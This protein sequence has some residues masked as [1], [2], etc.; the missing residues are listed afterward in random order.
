MSKRRKRE[1]ELDAA[2][3][4]DPDYQE[5]GR[6][7]DEQTARQKERL[8][9]DI[10]RQEA[11]RTMTTREQVQEELTKRQEEYK[12]LKTQ[13]T[14]R[15][16]L[17][18][19]KDDPEAIADALNEAEILTDRGAKWTKVRVQ[20]RIAPL[21]AAMS[22][23]AETATRNLDHLAKIIGNLSSVLAVGNSAYQRTRIYLNSEVSAPQDTKQ[24][25]PDAPR[26]PCAP[27]EDEIPAAWMRTLRRMIQEEI[28]A[29]MPDVAKG[30]ET[31]NIIPPPYPK[32]KGSKRYQGNRVTLPGLRVD[33]RLYDLFEG[34]RRK[35]AINAS[36][37]MQRILWAHFGRP[38]LSFEIEDDP[39]QEPPVED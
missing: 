38:P 29:M 17:A 16:I 35:L 1:E 8:E 4:A 31:A 10:A 19:V 30:A 39:A 12:Q 7:L 20:K 23:D 2:L 5:L 21:G 15:N 37:L 14:I 27:L 3:R 22:L 11:H 26:E 24:K 34:Q 25:T 13:F 28:K 6:L 32:V 33:K 36:E 9:Q 18:R